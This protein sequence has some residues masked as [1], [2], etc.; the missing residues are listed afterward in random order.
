MSGRAAV[1]VVI[2]ALSI[3]CVSG[4]TH[5]PAIEPPAR[6]D[7]GSAGPISVPPPAAEPAD[8]NLNVRPILEANCRPCHFKGGKMY[9]RLPFDRAETVRSLGAGLFTRIK[10]EGEQGVIRAFL[11]R[12]G[13]GAA[14]P[15][16]P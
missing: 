8:F 6:D 7:P 2:G 5:A 13:A 15:S 3:G 9:E 14:P 12:A 4:R 10:D 1:L 16:S 11:D